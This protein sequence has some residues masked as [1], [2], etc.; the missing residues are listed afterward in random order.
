MGVLGKALEMGVFD[1]LLFGADEVQ[2]KMLEAQDECT[3]NFEGYQRTELRTECV[4]AIL[5]EQPLT[6]D[7]WSRVDQVSLQFAALLLPLIRLM[8][9]HFP[10][11]KATSMRSIYQDLH[12]IVA[13]AGYLSLGT[14]WSR[15]IFRFSLPSPGQVWDIDQEN[16]DGTVFEASQAASI[17]ADRAAEAR[18]RAEQ[19]GRR[20]DGARRADTDNGGQG[21]RLWRQPSRIAKVQI[22]L[23][24][25]L[26]RFETTE[27]LDPE[28]GVP[29]GERV[30]SVFKSRAVYFNGQDVGGEGLDDHYPSL[31]GWL[32]ES[33]RARVWDQLLPLRWA[34]YAAGTWLLISLVAPYSPVIDDIQQVIKY[35][36]IGVAKYV[37]REALLFVI[38]G[39]I[40]IIA[41]ATAVVNIMLFSAYALRDALG[42]LLGFREG[43]LWG[44][45]GD[46]VGEEVGD[47]AMGHPAL[48]WESMKGIARGLAAGLFGSQ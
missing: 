36:L 18:W 15:N 45:A 9:K 25:M 31:P 1:D 4:R 19:S 5:A 14:R 11:S 22:V 24:P 20:R 32:R 2:K 26:E 37:G 12:T 13:E 47:N 23:W 44:A 48:T 38:E 27:Q 16:V 3:L 7:F 34:V 30:T 42:R 28:T 39:L 35:G 40:T 43:W 10:A 33:R 41:L 29:D 6:P 17:V 21:N 46:L 8:D